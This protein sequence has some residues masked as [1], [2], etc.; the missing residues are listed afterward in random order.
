MSRPL[1]RHSHRSQR[2]ARE[3]LHRF[4]KADVFGEH[5]ELHHVA[6]YAASE[7]IPAVRQAEDVQIWTPAV[8]VEQTASDEGA[9]L[10]LELDAVA[11]DDMFNRMRLFQRSRVDPSRSIGDDARVDGHASY[12]AVDS[13][14]GGRAYSQRDG[15]RSSRLPARSRCRQ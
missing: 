5:D 6:S 4:D 3:A 9:P 1:R 13:S 11:G 8:G 2:G 14:S 7:A 15:W 12:A 10:S